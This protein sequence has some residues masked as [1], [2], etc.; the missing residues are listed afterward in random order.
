MHEAQMHRHNAYITLT[1]DEEKLPENAQLVY[2]DFQLFMKRLRKRFAPTAN[3]SARPGSGQIRFYM[4]GEYGD[5]KGRPHFHAIIFNL[6]LIDQVYHHKTESGAKLYTS[7]ILEELW[8]HGMSTVGAVTF[9]SAAYVARY[10][11]KKKN[12]ALAATAYAKVN[13]DTG[14]VYQQVPEFA[15]MSRRPGIGLAWLKKYTADVYPRGKVIHNNQ[16]LKPPRYYDEYYKNKNPKKYQ[17]MKLTRLQEVSKYLDDNTNTRL[18]AKETVKKA[19]L[20]QLK[21]KL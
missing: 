14:E 21:R 8:P 18:E 3:L 2:R 13:L 9:E 17:Q 1:Y 7:K 5:K 12:G 20:D 4:S 10:V 19:Q 11:M 15:Q 6:H 16:E